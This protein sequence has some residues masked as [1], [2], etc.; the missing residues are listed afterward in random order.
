[1]NILTAN[2]I[3]GRLTLQVHDMDNVL[4]DAEW[5][6]QADPILVKTA[7]T[8]KTKALM[9]LAEATQMSKQLDRVIAEGDEKTLNEDG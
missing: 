7:K 4:Q 6:E 9:I 2:R 5:Q 3:I 8:L 1:M